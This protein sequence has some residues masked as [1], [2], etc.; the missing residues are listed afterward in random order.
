VISHF[1]TDIKNG[2]EFQTD[3]NGMQVNTRKRNTRGEF[4][5]VQCGFERFRRVRRWSELL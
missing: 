2:D 4:G 5:T 3:V 1:D